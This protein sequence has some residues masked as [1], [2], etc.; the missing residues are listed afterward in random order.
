[1]IQSKPGESFKHRCFHEKMIEIHLQILAS[2]PP[3]DLSNPT[4][5][6]VA[7]MTEYCMTLAAHY[8]A[9]GRWFAGLRDAMV[10][11]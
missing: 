5:Y 1:M 6:E 2:C 9:M 8:E 7:E 11:H 10:M 4:R 3:D